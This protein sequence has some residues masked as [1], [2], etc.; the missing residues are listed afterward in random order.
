V[1]LYWRVAAESGGLPISK[2]LPAAEATRKIPRLLYWPYKWLIFAP[3]LGLS[4]CLFVGM[5]IVML[6]FVG[7][8]VVN[9]TVLVWWAKFNCLMIPMRTKVVGRE[10]VEKGRSYVVVS[11]HQSLI[12]SILL[13]SQLK[14]DLKWVMKDELRKVPVFGYAAQKGGQILIDRSNPRLAYESLQGA[15]EKIAGGTS[16]MVLPEG[17]RSRTGELGEF[18]K[19]AF[20]L[21]QNLGIPVL[22]VSI[23]GTRKILPPDTLDLF[24]GRA[25]L[26]IHPP[27]E[28]QE[29][30]E[31]SMD[32]MISDVRQIIQR[33]LDDNTG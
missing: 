3:L 13:V 28:V 27:V 17:T 24:P 21:A 10:N 9:R 30:D 4:T 7:D 16:I 26:K 31:A 15:R 29:Y 8:L 2:T 5:G 14:M 20:W 12:D 11:N 6:P 33:G 18:K 22:P 1:L 25:V 32:R 19:G 23:I